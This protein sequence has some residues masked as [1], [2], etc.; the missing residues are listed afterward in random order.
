MAGYDE[1]WL[2][3]ADGAGWDSGGY[4][5]SSQNAGLPD[6]EYGSG[7][8]SGGYGA[9]AQNAG[10]PDPEYGSGW[11]SGG[12]GA[13][14]QN[15][16]VPAPDYGGDL[17]DSGGYGAS[18]WNAGVPALDYGSNL[19]DSGGYGAS[20][21]NAGVPAQ[22]PVTENQGSW[23]SGG[24]ADSA[25]NAGSFA[26]TAA[27]TAGGDFGTGGRE[28]LRDGNSGNSGNMLTRS[29]STPENWNSGGYAASA[30]NAG[31]PTGNR[32]PPT[33]NNPI[34]RN[35]GR[36]QTWTRD[37]YNTA[38]LGLDLTGLLLA[39]SANRS[40]NRMAQQQMQM[41]QQAQQKNAAMADKAN[42]QA[43]QS[44]N[45][46]RSLYNPQERA[47]R[48]MAQQQM[49]TARN[50]VDA[51]NQMSRAGKSK[52]TIDAEMRRAKLQGSTGAAT[53][54]T[55]GLDMGRQAQQSALSAAKNLT[56]NYNTAADYSGADRVANAGLGQAQQITGMLNNYL[57]N[58]VYQQNLAALRRAQQGAYYY[59]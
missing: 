5:A 55:A 39:N 11:D 42:A 27:Q 57:G 6:P 4:G 59:P 1:W 53:A 35:I 19:W 29:L 22:A 21:Q 32:N 8:D 37:N 13:S 49:S 56:S 52:A 45:E 12:Y 40:A 48:A 2:M 51:R 46:A 18:A 3:G 16:G 54:Y 26:V 20:A 14:A 7:W 36:A 30:Q 58:P 15:A 10:L 50:M 28:A 47:V 33:N 34:E 25:Q 43:T 17:W 31:V 44:F 24:Y 9:S 23:N 38:R 41:Q